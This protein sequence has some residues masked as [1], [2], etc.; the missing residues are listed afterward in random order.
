MAEH[1]QKKGSFDAA[2]K[3]KAVMC[4]EESTNRGAARKLG[5]D[6]R[7]IREWR[8]QKDDLESLN[9]KKRRLEGAGRKHA[10]PDMEEELVT[11]IEAL[12]AQNLRVTRSN[13]QSKALELARVY[14][15]VE[16]GATT[17]WIS[18][19]LKRHNFSLRRKTTVSQRLPQDLI[20]KVS[21]FIMATRNLR[22][23]RSFPCPASATWTRRRCGWT[24]LVKP[25]SPE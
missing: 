4:A 18:K 9:S 15:S 17:G 2:F 10:L 11:W 12:R 13:I 20:T 3:L 14:G 7:R 23:R 1:P 16:F 24:C 19:F 8:K 21:G 5:V 25:P 6:E 22:H